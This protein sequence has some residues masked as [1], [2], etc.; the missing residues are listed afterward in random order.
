VPIVE[1]LKPQARFRHLFKPGNEP[2]LE[3][4]QQWVDAQWEK[5]L[6]DEAATAEM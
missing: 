1:W 2:M 5:L 4:A 3:H 6:R